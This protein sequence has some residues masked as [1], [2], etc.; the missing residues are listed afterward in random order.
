VAHLGKLDATDAR[1][2]REVEECLSLRVDAVGANGRT[3]AEGA[4]NV[5]RRK[6]HQRVAGAAVHDVVRSG[7]NLQQEKQV[8]HTNTQQEQHHT[9]H[10]TTTHTR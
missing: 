1:Q 10:D 4:Q 9:T 8:T 5:P 7:A 6:I 3:D 2:A